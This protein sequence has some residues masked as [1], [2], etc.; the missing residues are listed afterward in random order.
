MPLVALDMD[1]ARTVMLV[2]GG[3]RS[4]KSRYAQAQASRFARVTFVATARRSD[5]EMRRKI[6]A[7]RRER[8]RDWKTVEAQRNLDQVI[9]REGASAD[10]LLVDCL[11]IYCGGLLSAR[12]VAP[13]QRKHL[14]SVIDAIATTRASVFLVSNEVGSG[15]VP[16]FKS[17]RLYRD[18]L[19]EVNQQVARVA[20]RVVLLVAGIPVPIKG[21]L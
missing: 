16:A 11:T 19:G 8:P 17:G 2:L 7:H 10:L 5:A 6:A 21:R 15:V 20:N 9:L 4:G 13:A 3:V 18:L 14:A 12:G 1:Q